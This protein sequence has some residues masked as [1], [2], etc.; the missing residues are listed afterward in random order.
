MKAQKKKLLKTLIK[1]AITVGL[2]VIVFNNIQFGEIFGIIE[3]ASWQYILVSIILY[4]LSQWVSSKR[5]HRV[6][7]NIDLHISKRSNTLLYLQG[8]FYNLF[9]PGGV[10]GDGYKIYMLNKHLGW[11]LKITTASLLID[12][13]TGLFAMIIL[14]LMASFWIPIDGYSILKNG[15]LALSII[16]SIIALVIG[17]RLLFPSFRGKLKGAI[18][19]AF[20]VQAIQICCFIAILKSL[21][22]NTD[23]IPYTLVFLVSGILSI[24]SFS[25]IGIREIIFL[26]ATLIFSFEENIAVSAGLLFSIITTIV[27]LGGIVT[28]FKPSLI[29]GTDT[30]FEPEVDKTI[31][32]Q[33]TE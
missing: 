23:Y 9:I 14:I 8:M 29:F 1:I 24:F 11:P 10:G 5:L 17:I 28:H 20:L 32:P 27:S 33:K 4:A 3:K 6:L 25:G 22:V 15:I 26:K 18:P 31:S 30:I 21:H 2:L 7:K 19:L 13:V 12:R 16:A